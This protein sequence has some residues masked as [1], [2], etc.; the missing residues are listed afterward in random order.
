MKVLSLLFYLTLLLVTGC[1]GLKNS[2]RRWARPNSVD[3]RGSLAV[4]RQ[5]HQPVPP[6]ESEIQETIAGLTLDEAL[7]RGEKHPE[8]IAAMAEL[9]SVKGRIRQARTWENPEL[10]GQVESASL[11]NAGRDDGEY[12]IGVSQKIPLGRRRSLAV[13][14]ESLTQEK[15]EHL[16]VI[17]KHELRQ[18]IRNA[19]FKVLYWEKVIGIHDQ[20][21][22]IA[23]AGIDLARHKVAAGDSIRLEVSQA[24]NLLTR[25]ATDLETARI[26]HAQALSELTFVIGDSG[27]IINS[28]QGSFELLQCP[29]FHELLATLPQSPYQLIANLEITIAQQTHE[30][31]KSQRIPDLTVGVGYRRITNAETNAVDVGI[32][33]PLPLFD[34]NSGNIHAAAADLSAAEARALANWHELTA[35]IHNKHAGLN[36]ALI[37]VNQLRDKMIPQTQALLNLAEEHYRSGEISLGEILP[38]RSNLMVLELDYARAMFDAIEAQSEL[39]LYLE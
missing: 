9:E 13:D 5:R 35:K 7:K 33:L 31:T 22:E 21:H 34:D 29:E 6:M 30:L 37:R 14:I 27:L 11:T 16:F 18:R 38:L 10:K 24:E 36:A 17:K 26:N 25:T 28:V 15:L 1:A 8:L 12:I 4:T 3:D 23:Q 20:A 2:D 32:G 39:L 19:Y